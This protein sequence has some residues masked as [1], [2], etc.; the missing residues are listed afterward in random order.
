[1]ADKHSWFNYYYW[2]D[3]K[4]APDFARTVDIH[5]KPGY[6]PVEMFT[7]PDKPFMLPRIAFKLL[8][9]KMGFR[10]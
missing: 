10:T 9:K 6:D 8:K 3:D 1:M 2:L 7:D 5:K 4:K